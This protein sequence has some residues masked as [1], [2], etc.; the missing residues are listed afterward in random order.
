VENSEGLSSTGR[1]EEGSGDSGIFNSVIQ[2]CAFEVHT[3]ISVPVKQLV[4]VSNPA[5]HSPS[6]AL[7]TVVVC[8]DSD[9]TR[10]NSVM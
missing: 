7:A 4:L 8:F 5:P 3:Q 1:E 10:A 2:C 9:V 6:I